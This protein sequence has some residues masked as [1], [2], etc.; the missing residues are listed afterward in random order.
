MA[1]ED[2][3]IKSFTDAIV[4][5]LTL[6][7]NPPVG[8]GHKKA[9]L[10]APNADKPMVI[11]VIDARFRNCRRVTPTSVSYTNLRAH[12]TDSDRV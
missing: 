7:P 1:G 4:P 8:R 5:I 12:E 6:E 2:E 3:E 10:A 11:R 9:M